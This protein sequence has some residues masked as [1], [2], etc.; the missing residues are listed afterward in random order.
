MASATL[1]TWKLSGLSQSRRGFTLVELMIAVAI[2]GVLPA[3]AIP[4]F[5]KYLFLANEAE[6]V[7]M[8]QETYQEQM[9]IRQ[10]YASLPKRSPT[11][12]V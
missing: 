8:L 10:T 11:R 6:G 2:I 7:R 12:V 4:S 1:T 5:Q 3:V 9:S